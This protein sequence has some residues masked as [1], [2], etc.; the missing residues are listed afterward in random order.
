M[1]SDRLYAVLKILLVSVSFDDVCF[2]HDHLRILSSLS[3]FSQVV[4]HVNSQ[5]MFSADV[6]TA[7]DVVV[8]FDIFRFELR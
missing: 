8:E 6:L 1:W 2:G 3:E 5:Q 7:V 4:H